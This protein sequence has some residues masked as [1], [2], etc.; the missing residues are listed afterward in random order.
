[1]SLMQE[2]FKIVYDS[3]KQELKRCKTNLDEVNNIID[4]H[5]TKEVVLPF[6]DFMKVLNDKSLLTTKIMMLESFLNDLN[7]LEE[8]YKVSISSPSH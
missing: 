2:S 4:D 1:M 7:K 3:R 5:Q 8:N 6:E